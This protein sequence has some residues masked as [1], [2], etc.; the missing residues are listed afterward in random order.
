M[1]SQNLLNLI[2]TAMVGQLGSPAL[3]AVGLGSMVNWLSASL[4]MGLGAGVQAITARRLGQGDTRGAIGALHSAMLI[5]LAIVLPYSLVL[6]QFSEK[7]FGVLS[8]DPEVVRLGGPYLAT[9]MCAAV[10]VVINFSF[11]GYWNGIGR[12]MVYMRTIV[13][14]HAINIALNWLLIYG[15]LGFPKLGVTGA[16]V[17]S[18]VAVCAG[19]LTYCILAWQHARDQGFLARGTFVKGTV[20][21]VL[22]LSLPA[23]VQNI[24]MS[25][26]FVAF[27]RIAELLGTQQLAVTSVLINLSMV[28]LLPSLGFGLA[29]TTLVGKSLGAGKKAEAALWGWTTVALA[30][31]AMAIFGGIL[32]LVP[33]FWLALFVKDLSA[34]SMGAVPLRLLGC[35]QPLDAVGLVLSQSL[36]GAGAARTVMTASIALQ[37]GLFLPVAYVIATKLDGGLTALWSAL[38]VWRALFSMTM[39][40]IFK[41]GKWATINV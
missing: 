6:S 39:A 13:V 29:S 21:G 11:R 35:A 37:W 38:V 40:V 3:A 2:D 31:I 16:A 15:K 8:S 41:R 36:L 22:R 18:A 32:A 24:F 1:L 9:R 30:S 17:A 10:F 14:I 26:G 5:A 4:F 20:R 19:T 27:Y 34:R 7:I 23:G 28:C 25:A 33:S 12:S